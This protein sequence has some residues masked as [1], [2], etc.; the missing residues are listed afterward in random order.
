M[1][2]EEEVVRAE[3][4]KQILE[5]K[6][7]RAALDGVR[8]LI[9]EQWRVSPVKDSEIRDWLWALYNASHKFEEVLR[10]HIETGKLAAHQLKHAA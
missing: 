6:L 9:I 2:P 1:T 10:S 8:D 3:R 4:A 5:D 7:V